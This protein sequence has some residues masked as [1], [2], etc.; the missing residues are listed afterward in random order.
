MDD[1]ELL[2]L[3]LWGHAVNM[4]Y[5]P[6]STRLQPNNN[7]QQNKTFLGTNSKTQLSCGKNEKIEKVLVCLFNCF[8]TLHLIALTNLK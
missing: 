6:S 4:N 8:R 7:E 2:R 5:T 1:I 3:N